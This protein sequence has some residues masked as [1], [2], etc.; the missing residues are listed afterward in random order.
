[1]V[2][3]LIFYVFPG[4][5]LITPATLNEENTAVVPFSYFLSL[6]IAW[7]T[8]TLPTT[9][10][11]P[12]APQ[13]RYTNL[14][15]TPKAF[16]PF[17]IASI[18]GITLMVL[19]VWS[20]ARDLNKSG[21]V[22]KK[23]YQNEVGYIP[24]TL[25][26]ILVLIT[27]GTIVTYIKTDSDLYYYDGYYKNILKGGVIDGWCKFVGGGGS[28]NSFCV[29]DIEDVRM[30]GADGSD[31]DDDEYTLDDFFRVSLPDFL[32]YLVSLGFVSL[33][34]GKIIFDSAEL[35]RQFYGSE[36]STSSG[37]APMS[38]DNDDDNSTASSPRNASRSK[39][40]K[41]KESDA[42]SPPSPGS[43][44]SSDP[45]AANSSDNISRLTDDFSHRSS[46]NESGKNI[47]R[48]KSSDL[49]GTRNKYVSPAFLPT[50]LHQVQKGA[51]IL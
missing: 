44:G 14:S 26:Y 18:T 32:S 9:L 45:E 22:L 48:S 1:M 25:L 31:D 47:K 41:S 13:N 46:N 10:P 38:W 11:S 35:Q 8:L 27:L 50:T 49:K 17:F 24:L 5:L 19:S 39:G 28:G 40:G 4:A 37:R 23:I 36:E 42:Y 15:F 16:L 20:L 12:Q 30:E 3:A 34:W 7:S 33:V 6:A 29:V 21:W 43:P 51:N 2:L